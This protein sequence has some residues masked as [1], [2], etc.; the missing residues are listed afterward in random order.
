LSKAQENGRDRLGKAADRHLMVV[1]WAHVPA[2]LALGL[3]NEGRIWPGAAALG[4][5]GA[6]TLA[7]SLPGFAACGR[8]VLAIA[9]VS[10]SAVA[11]AGFWGTPWQGLADLDGM[12]ALALIAAGRDW[13]RVAAS[14][15]ALVLQHGCLAAIGWEQWP[16]PVPGSGHG[17]GQW[18]G[19]LAFAER[20]S[21]LLLFAALGVW[22]TREIAR[23]A[24]LNRQT[25]LAMEE[26]ASREEGI[27]R[28]MSEAASDLAAQ[29]AEDRMAREFE[30]RV[31]GLVGGAA[32]A[33]QGVRQAAAKV[34]GVTE[35]AA[36]RTAVIAEAS[37]ETWASA[38]T[39]A[40]AVEQLA[41]S[42]KR[43]TEEVRDVSQVSFQAMEEAGGAN[44]TVQEL[45]DAATR[46]GAV[47]KVI[48]KIA[49]QT[50]L[51]ALNATIEAARAG[52]AGRGFSV[53]ANEVKELALQTGAATKDIEKEIV[54]IRTEMAKAM[55]AIDGMA[56][57]VANL[58]GI[59]VSVAGSMDEQ[60]DIAREIADNAMRA[61]QGTEAVLTN[62][63]AL[64]EAAALGDAAARDGSRD[65]D[66][67]AEKCGDV[68]IAVRDFVKTLLT[69]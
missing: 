56:N 14:A 2:F 22:A 7:Q 57:T 30:T 66:L 31:G 13:R 67:L 45:A 10:N 23:M 38:Q 62:L 3:A 51:L 16:F 42:I 26:A 5:A 12:G 33:A 47:V 27:L 8:W 44:Q 41:A 18:I 24:A 9:L 39:V 48:N 52:E 15:A 17:P 63:Q 20:V 60:G 21:T 50:N 36:Q 61:A 58:G 55:A 28:V 34:S 46:I 43:V 54:A 6:A 65:A 35:A 59:T 4:L 68:E 11:A 69:A 64:T 25:L 53:V 40:A 1:L 49:A 29:V 37:K 32:I 19:Y